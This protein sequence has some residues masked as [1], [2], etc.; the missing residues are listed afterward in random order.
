VA[1][2]KAVEKRKALQDMQEINRKKRKGRMKRR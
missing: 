2:V 1:N